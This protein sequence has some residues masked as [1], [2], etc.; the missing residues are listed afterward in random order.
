L[1]IEKRA[2]RPDTMPWR[3]KGKR[4]VAFSLGLV[5]RWLIE[6]S[7]LKIEEIGD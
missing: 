5:V 7:L 6:R 1:E 4:G 2:V 3:G